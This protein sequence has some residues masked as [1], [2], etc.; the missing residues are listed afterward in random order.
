MLRISAI[1]LGVT[2]LACGSGIVDPGAR[3]TS[4]RSSAAPALSSVSLAKVTPT[5]SRAAAGS[6]VDAPWPEHVYTTAT[7]ETVDVSVSTSYPAGDEIGRH[8][9]GFFGSLLHGR[10]LEL[11]KVYVAPL[12]Q[13]QAIC[14][15]GAVGCYGDDQLVLVNETAL[16]FAPEE[17][18]RH[19]YGHHIALNRLN[20]P[21]PALDWG[22]KHW[23]TAAGICA[24]VRAHRAY[25]GDEFLL[26][27]L[28]PGEAFA[29]TYRVLSDL[30]VGE[31]R[32]SWRLA[33]SSFY[34]DQDELD[35]V[36]QDVA[37]PWT[38]PTTDVFDANLNRR[39]VW[40]RRLSTPLDGTLTLNLAAPSGVDARVVV[41]AANGR[42]V[43]AVGRSPRGGPF[44]V[45]TQVC[46]ERSI[47][48]QVR[49][50]GSG[51]RRIELR[52]T[53]P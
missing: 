37:S 34:P 14:G 49:A 2:I 13:V 15:Q 3:A 31:T 42:K 8:W 33:D 19:E 16:G 32:P 4:A 40:E 21:W 35:A 9:A 36:D 22:P 12:D 53:L 24:R 7:G 45:N 25:P 11:L 29:E 38:G 27:K 6:I 30:K 48:V 26:Y 28:N 1:A 5:L 18:A 51:D 41:L 46:G 17:I 10:E 39:S 43:L 44:T 52:V 50:S 47:M 23:A 20:T